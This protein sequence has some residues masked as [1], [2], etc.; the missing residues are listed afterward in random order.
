M[1]IVTDAGIHRLRRLAAALSAG[2]ADHR[3]LCEAINEAIED[4]GSLDERLGITAAKRLGARDALIREVHQ[5]YF[6]GDNP[7][8]AAAQIHRLAR[9]VEKLARQG[10]L[11]QIAIDDPRHLIA[12]AIG[13]G[14]RFPKERHLF[15]V[16]SLQ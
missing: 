11:D 16:L 1:M 2:D 10:R 13:I 8:A 7:Y 15:N 4:G 12:D 9:E 5:R 14:P 6:P 3:W